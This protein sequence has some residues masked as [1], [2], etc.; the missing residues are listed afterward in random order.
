MSIKATAVKHYGFAIHSLVCSPYQEAL[1]LL[2]AVGG[3]LG[4]A[5]AIFAALSGLL[6]ALIERWLFFAEATHTVMLY[7]REQQD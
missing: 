2:F 6:G 1:L 7:Y 4:I 5:L 3:T